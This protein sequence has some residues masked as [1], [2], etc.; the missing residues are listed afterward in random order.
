MEKYNG[1]LSVLF[2]YFLCPGRPDFYVILH[3]LLAVEIVVAVWYMVCCSYFV[4]GCPVLITRI[5]QYTLLLLYF[6]TDVFSHWLV[7]VDG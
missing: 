4:L 6:S 1:L 5:I 2:V 3:G 7:R